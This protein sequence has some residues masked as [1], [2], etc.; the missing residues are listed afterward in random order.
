M[1]LCVLVCFLVVVDLLVM[2]LLSKDNTPVD[3]LDLCWPF[4]R[5][6]LLAQQLCNSGP[7]L[8][9]AVQTSSVQIFFFFFCAGL[10]VPIS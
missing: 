1:L 8:G 7:P 4:S 10:R 6:A 2:F 5:L 3:T 9:W